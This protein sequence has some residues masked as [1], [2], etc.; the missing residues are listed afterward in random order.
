M[1]AIEVFISYSHKDETLRDELAQHLKILHREGIIRTWYDREIS[2]GSDWQKQINANLQRARV[3]LLL[4]SADFIA[5]DYCWDV[6]VKKAMERHR[7]GG[8]IVVPVI[9]RPCDWMSTPFSKLQALPTGARPVV[10]WENRDEAFAD[11]TRAL[12]RTAVELGALPQTDVNLLKRLRTAL[13]ASK[14]KAATTSALLIFLA[15]IILHGLFAAQI[16]NHLIENAKFKT[17]SRYLDLANWAAFFNSEV[18]TISEQ[19]KIPLSLQ[20]NLIL[21]RANKPFPD[22][23]YPFD[24]TTDKFLAVTPQDYYKL[25]IETVPGRF[26]LYVFETDLDYGEISR[27][28]PPENSP[29]AFTLIENISNIK[30]P[31]GENKWRQLGQH[32]QLTTS[33]NSIHVLA[34]PWRAKDI[35][36]DYRKISTRLAENEIPLSERISFLNELLAKIALR[37]DSTFNCFF[38]EKLSFRH[39]K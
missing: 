5:S 15:L 33:I 16:A 27:L 28:L 2:V 29:R 26:Y 17:A 4:V 19:L 12:R 25:S 32:G 22:R 3:I 31:A 8:C 37:A 30:I 7:N 14:L 11:I 39:E 24:S 34:S 36:S 9:L 6:E 13:F 21:K 1:S 23:P 20:A 35:E 38:Y 18:A 10:D